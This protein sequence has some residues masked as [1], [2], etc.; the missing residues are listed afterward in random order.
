LARSLI[1]RFDVIAVGCWL[2]NNSVAY[3]VESLSWRTVDVSSSAVEREIHKKQA[4]V[5]C[6][7]LTVAEVH[8]LACAVEDITCCTIKA[9]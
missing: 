3:G 8:S 1:L 4:A 2:T 9:R 6:A 5:G 7:V